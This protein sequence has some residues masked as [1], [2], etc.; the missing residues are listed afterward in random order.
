MRLQEWGASKRAKKCRLKPQL[1]SD[2]ICLVRS[3]HGF[4]CI[5]HIVHGKAEFFEKKIGRGGF[6]EAVWC[7][8]TRRSGRRGVKLYLPSACP[9]LRQCAAGLR[10][11]RRLDRRWPWRTNTQ[12]KRMKT[13]AHGDV[14]RERFCASKASSTF[15][16]LWYDDGLG[17]ALLRWYNM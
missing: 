9:L 14:L 17:V 3:Q 5:D 10:A 13:D 2:G 7:R 11:G 15:G 1:V 8:L 4:H 16:N 12:T 6:A